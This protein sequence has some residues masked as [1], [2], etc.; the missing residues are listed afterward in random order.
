[1][2][3]V[4]TVGG[5]NPAVYN[6]FRWQ[7]RLFKPSARIYFDVGND[8]PGDEP[9]IFVNGSVT[10]QVDVIE[11][12]YWWDVGVATGGELEGWGL[13]LVC[14]AGIGTPAVTVMDDGGDT[15]TSTA[16]VAILNVGLAF[17]RQ[18]GDPRRRRRMGTSDSTSVTRRASRPMRNS[19][20]VP[21][22]PSTSA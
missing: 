2:E 4:A 16:P 8:A 20:T 15:D 10:A 22:G 12:G 19:S 21:T 6:E 1:M 18:M 9:D 11:V 14:G 7:A 3:D 17:E 13:G 5:K